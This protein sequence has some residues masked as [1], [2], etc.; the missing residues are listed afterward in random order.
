[1]IKGACMEHF[2]W[3]VKLPEMELQRS[4]A[5][6]LPWV[7]VRSPYDNRTIVQRRDVFNQ[8]DDI[9]LFVGNVLHW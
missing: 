1:M 8:I 3:Q 6:D 5:H 7:A 9:L 4:S 2:E